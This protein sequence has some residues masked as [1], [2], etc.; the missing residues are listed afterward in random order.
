MLSITHDPIGTV[1]RKPHDR[2]KRSTRQGERAKCRTLFWENGK[3]KTTEGTHEPENTPFLIPAY[4]GGK[5]V[6]I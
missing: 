2:L 3:R 5:E 6:I 4:I 1:P